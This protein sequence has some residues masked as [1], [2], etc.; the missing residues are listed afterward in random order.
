MPAAF[1]MT[2]KASPVYLADRDGDCDRPRFIDSGRCGIQLR[3]G[4]RKRFH[5]PIPGSGF[6]FLTPIQLSKDF[7]RV[8]S[9]ID[10]AISREEGSRAAI[11][12]AQY[13]PPQN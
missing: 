10:K 1:S 12:D 5:T 3:S 11:R 13:V 2:L 7:L 6:R 4:L 8:V 9:D